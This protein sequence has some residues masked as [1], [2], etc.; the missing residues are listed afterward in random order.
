MDPVTDAHTNRIENLWKHAKETFKQM[1]VNAF[2]LNHLLM[3][4]C[5][6][7]L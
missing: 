7:L 6:E 5:G 2:I 4:L 1:I 3:N